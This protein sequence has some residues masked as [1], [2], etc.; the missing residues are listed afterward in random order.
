MVRMKKHLIAYA[1]LVAFVGGVIAADAV[2]KSG[3]Q[4]GEKIPGPFHPLNI[5]GD[6]AGKKNCLFC[7]NGENPVAMIFA[8]R[9]SEQLTKLIKKIDGCTAKNSE[10]SMGSFVVYCSDDKNL[11]DTL[12]KVVKD[13]DLKQTVLAID[14]PAGPDK[15][16]V[17]KDAEVT[18]V[19]YRERV[20]KANFTYAKAAELNDKEIEKILSSVP[21]ILPEKK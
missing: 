4:V 12:K 14:N 20:V 1:A 3:P 19:L 10:C 16:E 21:K 18:V 8:K 2:V 6:Q 17:S 7:S 15:Y 11:E 5:N 13:A 9:D